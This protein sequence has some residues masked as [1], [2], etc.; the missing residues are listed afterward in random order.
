MLTQSGSKLPHSTN[1]SHGACPV[2]LWFEDFDA[3]LPVILSADLMTLWL[4]TV[5]ENGLDSR[6][7][8]FAED[9]FRGNDNPYVIPA[10]AGI[11]WC[12]A[13]LFSWQSLMPVG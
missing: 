7:P 3:T 2:F 9:K 6:S 12:Y 1:D 5:H 10:K 8:A 4:T 11:H 13:G